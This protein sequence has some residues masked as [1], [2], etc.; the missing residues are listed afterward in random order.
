MN[1]RL[2]VLI[3]EDSED[4]ALLLVLQLKQ[5]GY[6]L[7]YTRVA[8]QQQMASA[9]EK[10]YWDLVISDY[11]LPGFSGIDALKMVK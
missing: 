8:S 9:L 5:A 4:D 6:D 10:D 3:V 2:K 11:S 1:E 7:F